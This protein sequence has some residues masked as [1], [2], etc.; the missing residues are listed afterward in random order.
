MAKK[1]KDTEMCTLEQ[2]RFPSGNPDL[3]FTNAVPRDT[4]Y[5]LSQARS[6]FLGLHCEEFNFKSPKP[7]NCVR[8]DGRA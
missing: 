2:E 5:D 4:D 3:V 8:K 6:G 7:G 1:T